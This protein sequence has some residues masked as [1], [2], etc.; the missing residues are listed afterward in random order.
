M[1]SE[2]TWP[3]FRTSWGWR[4]LGYMLQVNTLLLIL[5][6]II[7]FYKNKINTN[8]FAFLWFLRTIFPEQ[9]I[10]ILLDRFISFDY[11][12]QVWQPSGNAT[13]FAV[14][15]KSFCKGMYNWTETSALSIEY[16]IVYYLFKI[17]LLRFQLLRQWLSS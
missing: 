2:I 6:K 15:E 9:K 3:L 4:S 17:K 13:K 16:I 14:D 8:M 12:E 7:Y 1:I 11:S 5:F 10:T